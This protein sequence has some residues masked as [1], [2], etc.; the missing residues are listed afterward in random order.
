MRKVSLIGQK[1]G[2]L[3]VLS[4]AGVKGGRTYSNCL[5]D[6]GNMVIVS[7]KHLKNGHTKSCGCYK[8][9]LISRI[10]KKT[11]K[12]NIKKAQKQAH[13]NNKKHQ[14]SGTRIYRIWSQI[15]QRCQN[16]KSSHYQYYGGKGI[17]ICDEWKNNFQAFEQWATNN[18]YADNLTIDRVNSNK[19]YEPSNC[20]WIPKS[21]NSAR[22]HR[23]ARYWCI[24]V[25]NGR[26]AEF[27]NIREFCRNNPDIANENHVRYA[28]SGKC[29]NQDG[30]IFGK[31]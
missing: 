25:Q 26:Y 13:E 12:T 6:C 30:V 23:D 11:G 9:D 20:R 29:K 5:C 18:G 4:D 21:E 15:K 16:E 24:D 10:G 14:M 1:F 31:F 7:N 22:I 3:T 28:V 2:R 17:C 27:D 8:N 19:N